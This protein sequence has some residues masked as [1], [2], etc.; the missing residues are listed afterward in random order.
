M[1]YKDKEI[2]I[3]EAIAIMKQTRVKVANGN[4]RSYEAAKAILIKVAGFRVAQTPLEK[5]SSDAGYADGECP[6]CQC[7]VDEIE[8][9]KF[10]H[11]CGQRLSW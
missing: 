5:K 1:I 6:S 10:C 3:E 2:T 4:V 9:A 7:L 8:D 11:E